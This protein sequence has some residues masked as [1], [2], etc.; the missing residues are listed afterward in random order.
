MTKFRFAL[1]FLIISGSFLFFGIGKANAATYYVANAGN[2]ACNGTSPTIGTSGNCAWQTIAKVN[3]SSF[4][5]GDS[6]LFNKGDTWREQLT[7]PS[8]GTSGNPI[9]F[10]AYGTGAKPLISGADIVTGWTNYSGNIYVANVSPANIPSQLYVDGQFYDIAHYPNSGYLTATVNSSDTTS[11]VDANLG[12]TQSQIVGA[13]VVDKA[14]TWNLTSNIALS[15]SPVTGTI[16]LNGN[17]YNG[18]IRMGTGWGFYLQNMLWMLNSP[19]EWFY[20][21]SAGKLYLW[22][23]NSDDPGNHTVEVSSRSYGIYDSGKNYITIQNLAIANA[24]Q[25]DVSVL[26]ANNVGLNNL[27]LSGGQMGIYADD[28]A[29]STV[30]NNSVQNALSDGM[31]FNYLTNAT[32][33]NNSINN[34]GNVGASPKGAGLGIAVGGVSS[35]VSIIGNTVTNSGYNGITY[36]GDQI[37]VQNNSVDKSCLVLDDCGGI[38]TSNA[39]HAGWTSTISGNTIT[40]SM[41]NSS[42]ENASFTLAKGI[43]LDNLSHGYTVKNNSI[44]NADFGIMIHNGYNNTVTGNTVDK[45]RVFGLFLGEDLSAG[46]MHD[47]IITG[48]TFETI[49]N[50][51]S[52]F[53]G[54]GTGVADYRSD[55][56]TIANFGTYNNNQYCHPNMSY[57]VGTRQT[58]TVTNYTLADWQKATGQDLNSTDSSSP[59]C[60]P[61]SPSPDTTPPAAPTGLSVM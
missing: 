21:A 58:G 19:G 51:S 40:N 24:N 31:T 27:S 57:T 29:G 4:S 44:T 25:D 13:T 16:G 32:I 36:L 37:L 59:T 34:A 49:E 15:Y 60:T 35:H 56:G 9:T 10:D 45:A 61:T 38:Y 47:N 46:T 3:S 17:V 30:Q 5:P 54:Y 11:I 12:L 53:S 22:T 26:Y 39:S 50:S 42:G 6:I 20:D 14:V 55:S 8:S 52:A 48:N 33:S 23:A 2:D 28:W 7:I 43:Y 41:G 1:F 18:S